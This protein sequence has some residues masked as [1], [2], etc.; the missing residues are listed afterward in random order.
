MNFLETNTHTNKPFSMA[1]IAITAA[2]VLADIIDLGHVVL[3]KVGHQL[4]HAWV[5]A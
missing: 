3:Q 4:D 1:R 5:G 2:M